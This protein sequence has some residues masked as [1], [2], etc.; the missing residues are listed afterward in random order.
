MCEYLV[1]CHLREVW[2]SGHAPSSSSNLSPGLQTYG[3]LCSSIVFPR[4]AMSAVDCVYFALCYG[5]WIYTDVFFP[6]PPS[7]PYFTFS[8]TRGPQRCTLNIC[9]FL[10]QLS[11]Y[12][13]VHVCCVCISLAG[14][15]AVSTF[16]I[17]VFHVQA[18]MQYVPVEKL[19]AHMHDTFGQV[20]CILYART[21]GC[22]CRWLPVLGRCFWSG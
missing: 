19:A 13:F 4:L 9:I 7:F 3:W 21:L 20:R 5:C 17:H 8:S 1:L 10:L 15:N 6:P 2:L 22:G 11:V 18:T 12:C 14:H 16:L